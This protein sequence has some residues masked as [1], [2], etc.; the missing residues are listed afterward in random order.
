MIQKAGK[1]FSTAYLLLMFCVYP[2]YLENG[3]YDIGEA[4]MHFFLRVSL[5]AFILLTIFYLLHWV[6]EARSKWK[7][8]QRFLGNWEQ[9]S[10]VDLLMM[11]YATVVFLSYVASTNKKEALWGAEGWY[12]GLVPTLLLCA[13]YFLISRLWAGSNKILY[14]I[15]ASSA[16]VFLLGI[17][18]R[19]SLY[20]IEIEGA[21]PDF[22]STLGNINWF[23]GFL[24]V[25][26][27]LGIGY[28]VV[29]E[30]LFLWKQLLFGVYAFITFAAGL[31]QGSDSIFLWFGA[32]FFLLL[33]IAIQKTEYVKRWF[34]LVLIWSMAS[35]TVT[36]LRRATVDKYNYDVSG[37][38]GYFTS[39]YLFMWIAAVA[40]IGYFFLCI[41][42]GKKDTSTDV[43]HAEWTEK[44]SKYFK[45]ILLLTVMIAV[46]LWIIL[47]A[48][49]TFVGLPFLQENTL[50][51]FDADWGH[52]RGV[53]IWAGFKTFSEQ[54]LLQKLIGAGPD[55]F[56]SAAYEVSEIALA[57]REHF[58]SARLTNAHCECVTVLVNTGILGVCSYMGLLLTCVARYLKAGRDN[59]DVIFYV[60]AVSVAGYFVHNMVSFAQVLNIPFLFIIIGMAEARTRE[61]SPKTG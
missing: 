39:S 60:F 10:V 14:P 61:K 51:T 54:P 15:M 16:V 55:C 36:I 24:S 12:M 41:S 8:R 46:L 17:C 29:G 23:C 21:Q 31:A 59:G 5:A 3:Y 56:A 27:S 11:C 26:A 34:L 19:F 49:N 43:G 25:A 45:I 20:P 33:W 42:Q 9:V 2:F 44:N 32:V 7:N 30:G 57:L 18:N 6:A 4:K 37:F 13:L 40:I 48:V 52:G 50:F 22:I 53:A 47:S 38:C 1:L 28:F 58:G 35:G